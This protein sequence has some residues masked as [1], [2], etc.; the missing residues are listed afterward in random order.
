MKQIKAQ[1]QLSRIE[2]NKTN[3]A[4]VSRSDAPHLKNKLLELIFEE[5]SRNSIEL[6]FE[7][8]SRDSIE[9]IF[10][11]HSRIGKI[12]KHKKPKINCIG[13]GGGGMKANA[14]EWKESGMGDVP[15]L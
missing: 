4:Q 7:E 14:E 3:K 1:I 9:L 13:W 5:H 6:I 11:E 10:E 8:H 15:S 12:I 2:N